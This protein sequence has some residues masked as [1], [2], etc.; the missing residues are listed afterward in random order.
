MEHDYRIRR[1][2]QRG[3]VATGLMSAASV[4]A[5]CVSVALPAAAQDVIDPG[6]SFES[7]H[8][9]GFVWND[10]NHNGVQD[11]GEAGLDG[12]TVYIF[13]AGADITDTAA[14]AG[15]GE[16]AGGGF[17]A[18]EVPL[19]EGAPSASYQVVI[20]TS[21]ISQGTLATSSDVGGDPME[22]LDS[23][24]IDNS[25]GYSVAGIEQSDN[26]S[27]FDRDF[28]FYAPQIT[29]PGTGTP[30]YWKNHPD[31]WPED[32]VSVGGKIYTAQTAI[33]LLGK[34]AKDKT[35]TIFS[36]LISAV[37]NVWAGNDSSCVATTIEAAN[38]WLA[39]HPVGSNV[40]ASSAFWA[41]DGEAL[42][43]QMD[44]Y[45]N[46]LLCAPHRN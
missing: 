32:G 37:L 6:C 31:A 25:K 12:V 2:A 13:E 20:V 21:S 5:L 24:G 7:P 9:C 11:A 15:Q 42:H 30:G 28:G 45:N 8:V 3:R 16:T 44:A 4:A 34:V 41:L 36:S 43:K 22:N 26:W 46:G 18:I 14:S 27:K 29:G 35:I 19:L 39:A 1:R 17:Y 40:T 38:V 33:P 23:D 10:A